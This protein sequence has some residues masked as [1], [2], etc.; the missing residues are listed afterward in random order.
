MQYKDNKRSR[1]RAG[2]LYESSRVMNVSKAGRVA[3]AT[4]GAMLLWGGIDK[5]RS[6]PFSALLKVVSGS[7]LLYRGISGNCP[8]SAMFLADDEVR[9]TPAV[10]IR[11]EFIVNRP[12]A[13]VYQAWRQLE[14]LP[15]FMKHIKSVELI[16][17]THSKWTAKL[18]GGF[19]D[20]VWDA[21]IVLEETNNVLGWRSLPDSM[22]ENAGKVVFEDAEDGGTHLEVIITYRPPA[23]LIGTGIAKLLNANFEKLVAEDVHNFRQF[24]EEG[25][26]VKETPVQK[27][28]FRNKSREEGLTL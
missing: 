17:G 12:R 3:S 22:I 14:N 19:G 7:Y 1:P 6:S 23:G 16:S 8:L 4:A 26:S 25:I 11:T 24:V 28:T 10:N 15:Q 21:E 2:A 9:H 27:T 5:L 18:P 20:F 13:E